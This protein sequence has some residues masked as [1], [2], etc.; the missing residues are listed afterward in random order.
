[1]SVI[2]YIHAYAFPYEE[3]VPHND[4][5][6][7]SLRDS[8]LAENFALGDAVRDFNEVMP[9]IIPTGF[10]PSSAVVTGRKADR[11]YHP[12]SISNK[13]KPLP[14]N[15]EESSDLGWKL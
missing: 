8:I 6:T 12:P 1:M 4:D 5:E 15:V 7:Q 11:K 13:P 10:K 9:I 2:S 3:Y 14:E